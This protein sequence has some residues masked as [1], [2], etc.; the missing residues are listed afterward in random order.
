MKK[1]GNNTHHDNNHLENLIYDALHDDR[2]KEQ[3]IYDGVDNFSEYSYGS[4]INR[5]FDAGSHRGSFRTVRKSVDDERNENQQGRLSMILMNSGANSIRKPSHPYE[6]QGFEVDVSLGMYHSDDYAG[7]PREKRSV[8][9]DDKEIDM[10]SP[11]EDM[12]DEDDVQARLEAEILEAT[13]QELLM[14]EYPSDCCPETCYI[15]F[16]F[17]AGGDPDS[18]FWQGWGNLRI[19]TFRLIEN[20]YFETAV[21]AMILISSLALVSSN[22]FDSNSYFLHQITLRFR[23]ISNQYV[24]LHSGIRG[25]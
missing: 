21:I 23:T 9:I 3:Y 11:E 16:P 22:I 14:K 25:R 5:D 8:V 7:S 1:S 17:L 19:K 4:H 20:K 13:T 6:S 18:P 10:F 2:S 12:D 15:R 24:Y